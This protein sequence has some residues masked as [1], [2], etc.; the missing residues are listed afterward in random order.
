MTKQDVE[1][2]L[3]RNGESTLA[4][5]M[6]VAVSGKVKRCTHQD[7]DG[8]LD[9]DN[10]AVVHLVSEAGYAGFCKEHFSQLAKEDKQ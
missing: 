4:W 1:E 3:P 5:S 9:C 7:H 6:R 2:L 8:N 10:P